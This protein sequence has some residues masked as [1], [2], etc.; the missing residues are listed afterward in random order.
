MKS[1]L[2]FAVLAL[3][4]NV[5]AENPETIQ[6]ELYLD[7]NFERK[8][9]EPVVSATL[10]TYVR[11]ETN[12]AQLLVTTATGKKIDIGA[13]YTSGDEQTPESK[14]YYVEC[15]GGSMA[16]QSVGADQVLVV[17]DYIR[18]DIEGCDG[19]AYIQT[20]GTSFRAVRCE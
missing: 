18:G 9:S 13:F 20:E 11:D 3:S 8:V 12:L 1:I 6:A 5:F 14:N 4:I 16:V 15:D 10:K 7:E 19:T 17:S 2:A